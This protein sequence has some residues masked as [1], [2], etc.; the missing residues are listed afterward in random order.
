MKLNTEDYLLILALFLVAIALLKVTMSSLLL[1]K[2]EDDLKERLETYSSPDEKYYSLIQD[3]HSNRISKMKLLELEFLAIKQAEF[4]NEKL[5]KLVLEG[6]TQSNFESRK[7]YLRKLYKL[8]LG[9][10]Q[11]V[12]EPSYVKVS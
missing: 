11:K 8:N 7:M 9:K 1:S 5:K 2:G 10:N 4:M 12:E 6:I 3:L